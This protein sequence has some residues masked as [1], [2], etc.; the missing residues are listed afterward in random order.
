MSSV[1][2]APRI[3]IVEDSDDDAE[4]LTRELRRAG[5][6]STFQRVDSAA[7]VK[8]ALRDGPW[9]I[10]LSDYNLPQQSFPDILKCLREVD[11]D[12]PVIVVSGS[13]G[14]ENAVALM[15]EGVA[16]FIFKG[17]LSRLIPAIQRELSAAAQQ[18]ARRESDQR[19]RD[20]VEVSGDWIW[21]TDE[22]HRY[23]FFSNRFHEAE[24]AP[25]ASLGKTPW[26][27]AG[28]DVEE[29]EHWQAHLSDLEAHQTFRNFLFS[30]V[31][32][33]GNRQHVSISGVPVFDRSGVFRGYRGTAT[34]E[35]PV[36]EAFWR[37]EEAEA[38]LRDAVD[39]ISEG[40]V[41]FDAEDRIA[42]V[43]DAFRK[44]YPD[45]TDLAVPGVPFEDILRAAVDRGVYPDAKR[46]SSEWISARLDD[47]RDLSGS[48]VER[49]A[50]GRW[51]LVT[52]RRMSNGG[53]AGL[54]MD[55][56]ALKKAEAQRDHLAYHDATTGLPNKALF[57]DRLTQAI[58]RIAHSGGAVAVACLELTSLNDIRDSHGLDAGDTGDPRSGSPSERGDR[59][60]RDRLSHRRRP[61]PGAARRVA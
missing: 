17:N 13:I 36:V 40:F 20:I 9:D 11:A 28:A 42:M 56:T 29:D 3:L 50:D 21:E 55:I 27:L 58:G 5:I 18:N 51:V 23:T 60:G 41:I 43:N 33:T 26:E 31:T 49:L 2:G 52:E 54:R 14:E 53:I 1:P 22:N 35:T 10:V 61:V 38:L 32:P 8:Q 46:N 7:G 44:L 4:L 16:D 25:A 30:F 39:S 24:W 59:L 45:I 12:I 15:R 47:H 57:T 48:I 37:A 34:D 19:F 6:E